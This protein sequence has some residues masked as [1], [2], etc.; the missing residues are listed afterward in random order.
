MSCHISSYL[1]ALIICLNLLYDSNAALN[2]IFLLYH[3]KIMK[4]YPMMVTKFETFDGKN[5]F[6]PTKL[7]GAVTSP[8]ECDEEKHG[9]L[10]VVVEYYTTYK[11]IYG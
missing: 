10:S 8:S 11:Y 2:E 1:L 3:Q 6:D 7:C 5:P 4:K 9:I